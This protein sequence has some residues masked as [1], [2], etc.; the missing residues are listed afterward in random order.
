MVQR[1]ESLR[2]VLDDKLAVVTLPVVNLIC[3]NMDPHMSFAM[4]DMDDVPWLLGNISNLQP[5]L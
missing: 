5:N 1:W 2:A 3:L 4:Y